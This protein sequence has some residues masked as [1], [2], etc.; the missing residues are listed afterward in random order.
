MSVTY[1]PTSRACWSAAPPYRGAPVRRDAPDLHASCDGTFGSTMSRDDGF[2][3]YPGW[4]CQ[5]GCHAPEGLPGW[6]KPQEGQALEDA[7]ALERKIRED[8]ERFRR[9]WPVL[10][11]GRL[12][13]VAAAL[14]VPEEP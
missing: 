12:I 4:P 10:P 14:N 13:D 7:L 8:T 9:A 5:C 2:T 6:R 3:Y 1:S 11:A